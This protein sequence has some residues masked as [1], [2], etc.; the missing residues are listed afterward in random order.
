V[1]VASG[2]RASLDGVLVTRHAGGV[3]V[4]PGSSLD[5]RD[6]VVETSSAFGVL[7]RGTD[8]EPTTLRVEGLVV[9][10]SSAC[11]VAVSGNVQG[12]LAQVRLMLTAQGGRGAGPCAVA[13]LDVPSTFSVADTL[14][15]LSV[16]TAGSPGD[17]GSEDFHR[18]SQELARRLATHPATAESAFV[19]DAIGRAR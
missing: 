10:R 3:E 5:A 4:N 13:A 14:S 18:Q 17:V 2:G 1:R 15:W 16:S 12:A 11:G 6:V 9:H 7:A 19:K 8:A